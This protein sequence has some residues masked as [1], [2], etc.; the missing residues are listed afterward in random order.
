MFVFWVVGG[1]GGGWGWVVVVWGGGGGCGLKTVDIPTTH[2]TI[3][4][5]YLVNS[6]PFQ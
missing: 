2:H 3:S 5:N 1:F 6:I 4:V